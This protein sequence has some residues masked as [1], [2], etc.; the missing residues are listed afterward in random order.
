VRVVRKTVASVGYENQFVFHGD[1]LAV[2]DGLSKDFLRFFD[3]IFVEL[4]QLAPVG[5]VV[6][7]L[8][9]ATMRV[10][11]SDLEGHD[12]VDVNF[13]FHF[14]AKSMGEKPPV[15]KGL[16]FGF[17]EN[18]VLT[19]LTHSTDSELLFREF[20]LESVGATTTGDARATRD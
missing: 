4:V 14:H 1:S 18:R 17:A 8:V 20:V 11:Q 7:Q 2:R 10:A 9:D 3:T 13:N 19:G 12:V 5:L 6:H 15:V 16:F